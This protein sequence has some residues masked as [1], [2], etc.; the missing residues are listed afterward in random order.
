MENK[1][2]Y[3]RKELEKTIVILFIL[4]FIYIFSFP[5]YRFYK[6]NHEIKSLQNDILVYKN[7]IDEMKHNIEFIKS[8][9]GIE[10]WVKEN[11]K[12]TKD[13]EK[14]YIFKEKKVD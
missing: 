1:L 14:I 6:L 9:E 4:L 3:K 8:N 13:G 12:L 5:L 2:I 11:F 10:I 7:K